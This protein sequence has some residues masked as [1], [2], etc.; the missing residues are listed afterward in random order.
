MGRFPGSPTMVR[1]DM[2]S[3]SGVPVGVERVPPPAQVDEV[4]L[5][6]EGIDLEETPVSGAGDFGGV[7]SGFVVL[8]A[9]CSFVCVGGEVSCNEV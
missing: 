5:P 9:T 4:L 2:R 1:P 8:D 6:P 3:C 7:I